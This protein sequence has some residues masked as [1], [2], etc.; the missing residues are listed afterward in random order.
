MQK[1]NYYVNGGGGKMST[2]A[3]PSPS[4]T[5]SPPQNNNNTAIEGPSSNQH[6]EGQTNG[7]DD[8]NNNGD[9]DVE[10]KEEPMEWT[11]D[12]LVLSQTPQGIRATCGLRNLGNSCYLNSVIQALA[13]V[14]PLAGFLI[15]GYS[16]IASPGAGAPPS[17]P[18][19][20]EFCDFLAQTVEK[21][22]CGRFRDFAPRDLTRAVIKTVPEFRING[23][24]DAEEAL[25]YALNNLHDDL[26]V[27]VMKELHPAREALVL[28]EKERK[29]LEQ[30]AKSKRKLPK[31]EE[32]DEETRKKK[33]EEARI[34]QAFE[35]YKKSIVSDTFQSLL[36]QRVTCSVCESTSLTVQECFNL[37]LELPSKSQM[38]TI[39]SMQDIRAP[40]NSVSVMSSV[41]P[42]GKSTFL[43]SSASSASLEMAPGSPKGA[44]GGGGL[45][46]ESQDAT[47][48]SNGS[49]SNGGGGNGFWSSPLT[50]LKNVFSLGM[51]PH[52]LDLDDCLRS[53]FSPETL[54]GD[55]QYYCENCKS[56]VDATK[57]H[58]LAHLP[59]I[60]CLHLKRFNKS[61]GTWGLGS[62]KN[63]TM[64]RFPLEGLDLK[65]FCG[66]HALLE[67]DNTENGIYDLI[68][69]IRHSGRADSGHYIATCKS[70]Q[71]P[72]KWFEF[73]DE[74]V[75][76]IT[77]LEQIQS[78]DA[79]LLFYSK[80]TTTLE[81]ERKQKAFTALQKS[82]VSSSLP[83][84]R[85]YISK[86][87]A[88]KFETMTSPGMLE[89][90]TFQCEH[91]SIAYTASLDIAERVVAVN[92]AVL[93][94][95]E[96]LYGAGGGV[97][98]DGLNSGTTIRKPPRVQSLEVCEFCKITYEKMQKRRDSE[99]RT[100]IELDRRQPN[101]WY[102]VPKAWVNKWIA[103][104]KN[105][106]GPLGRGTFNGVSPPGKMDTES[107][108]E[109]D[110]L[111]P[112]P[113]LKIGIHYR[114]VNRAVFKYWENAYGRSGPALPRVEN[115]IYSQIANEHQV[116]EDEDEGNMSVD[117]ENGHN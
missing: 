109:K 1:T 110:I 92:S 62:A 71:Q 12:S 111:T 66:S 60:L 49:G 105:D 72:Q 33:E 100:I 97:A 54:K 28:L 4:T 37:A 31:P 96:T 47:A 30:E 9:M 77:N 95:L 6:R 99:Y 32:K 44:L 50:S 84:D 87:W 67:A 56:K 10:T 112:K 35:P 21:M 114:A 59:E 113:N 101:L 27:P 17:D 64:V 52:S 2:T 90:T 94:S 75:N 34:S 18:A 81:L 11:G 63:S 43:K 65:P 20:R 40:S 88:L 115:D 41:I 3:T 89:N 24:Q 68:G 29:A 46:Q 107:L 104:V 13:N 106:I 19:R 5:P 39:P 25:N 83:Q 42:N 93:T 7:N 85:F 61:R 80:R 51:T 58:E 98:A 86:F 91:G 23:Q 78:S 48:N 26:F 14:P 82:P 76:Q 45:R 15:S 57:I 16:T 53:F 38:K 70:K 108:L 73:D 69:V 74:F 103:F 22:W 102:M 116:D 117:D 36:A 55:E 79:Y 8:H